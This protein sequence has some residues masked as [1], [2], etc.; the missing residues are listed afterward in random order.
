MASMNYRRKYQM[1]KEREVNQ[2]TIEELIFIGEIEFAILDSIESKDKGIYLNKLITSSCENFVFY[3]RTNQKN[4]INKKGV[5]NLKK[6]HV[7]EQ[8]FK[9][10]E[11]KV[12]YLTA[13]KE[14]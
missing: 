2:K 4:H 5:L 10:M 11:R 14:K 3:L 12:V 6:F 1:F 8:D 7:N 13:K 9:I